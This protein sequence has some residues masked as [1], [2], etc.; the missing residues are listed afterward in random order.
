[1][2]SPEQKEILYEYIFSSFSEKDCEER[3]RK[4]VFE[5]WDQFPN[6][7]KDDWE[8]FINNKTGTGKY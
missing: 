6:Q 1:M 5:E 3:I 7:L 8:N 2:V 4:T